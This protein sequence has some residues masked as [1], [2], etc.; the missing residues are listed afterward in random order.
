MLHFML[1]PNL[2]NAARNS[3]LC[4]WLVTFSSV[5][6]GIVSFSWPVSWA[7]LSYSVIEARTMS[8]RNLILL[9]AA[10]PKLLFIWVINVWLIICTFGPLP[11]TT[12]NTTVPL[13]RLLFGNWRSTGRQYEEASPAIAD[14]SPI[15]FARNRLRFFR[16]GPT[17][18]S[19]SCDKGRKCVGRLRWYVGEIDIIRKT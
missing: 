18:L 9:T 14:Q 17:S 7:D 6:S 10:K 15:S 13:I 19:V 3:G 2:I 5:W 12:D 4:I 8:W 16:P 11:L 1:R